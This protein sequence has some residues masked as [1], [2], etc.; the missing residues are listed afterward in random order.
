MSKFQIHNLSSQRYGHTVLWA[1]VLSILIV[2]AMSALGR[3]ARNF[4]AALT[5]KP[6][7]AIYLLLKDEQLGNTTLIHT[8]EDDT[9]RT[10]LAETPSGTKLI[11]LRKNQQW[12]AD[13]IEP[14]HE[15]ASPSTETQ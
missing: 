2:C 6:D 5:D 4:K 1:V 14:L 8:N 10:Y 13:L 12:Y 15:T 11:T 9:V 7:V 3:A